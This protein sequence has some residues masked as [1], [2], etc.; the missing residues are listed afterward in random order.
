MIKLLKNPYVIFP[1][2]VG[3]TISTI[4]FIYFFTLPKSL[5]LPDA[6]YF[7]DK[8]LPEAVLIDV[9][10]KEDGYENLRKGKVLVFFL[11]SDC[12]ACK[13]EV[14]LISTLYSESD[15]N[16][17]IYGIA[18]ENEN[19]I[20][21]Y[22]KQNNVKFPIV[23]DKKGRLSENLHIRYFPTKFLIEDGIIVKTVIGSSPDK[24]KFLQD[25]NLGEIQQ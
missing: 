4:F 10:T 2:L 20:E 1:A 14:S 12:N 3:L 9:K 25:F 22:I 13:K 18:V 6:V 8:P 7:T 23:V 19:K 5:D 15:T 17:K 21:E 24:G 11:L 16:L